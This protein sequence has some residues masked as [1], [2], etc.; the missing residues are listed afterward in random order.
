MTH[1]IIAEALSPFRPLTYAE[2]YYIELGYQHERG[3]A[4][5]FEYRRAYDEGREARR[6]LHRGAME[7][8]MQ[9]SY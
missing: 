8:M 4:N 1:P 2:H 5:E 9:C 6:L 7:A 3:K